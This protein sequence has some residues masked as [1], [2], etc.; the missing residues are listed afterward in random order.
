MPDISEL[1]EN[2]RLSYARER[3]RQL[4]DTLTLA[5]FVKEER[6]YWLAEAG[7]TA[8]PVRPLTSATTW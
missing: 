4:A 5:R 7:G 2:T 6:D 3:A 8:W 1:D